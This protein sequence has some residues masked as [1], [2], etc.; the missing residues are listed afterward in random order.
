MCTSTH[1]VVPIGKLQTESVLSTLYCRF[2]HAALRI[3]A[4]T[5]TGSRLAWRIGEEIS[6]K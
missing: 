5:A 4:E 6:V 1:K 3:P 2:N